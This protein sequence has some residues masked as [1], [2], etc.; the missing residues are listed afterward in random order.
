MDCNFSFKHYEETLKKALDK[1]Y[2]FF[3]FGEFKE[4]ENYEKVIFLRHDVDISP[5]SAIL[6]LFDY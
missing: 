1:G 3:K 5:N 4:A 6:L 2:K